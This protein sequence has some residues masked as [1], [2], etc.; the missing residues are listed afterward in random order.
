MKDSHQDPQA[1]SLRRSKNFPQRAG[2]PVCMQLRLWWP[3]EG[4]GSHGGSLGL[5]RELQA[6]PPPLCTRAPRPED[7][8]RSNRKGLSVAHH[9]TGKARLFGFPSVFTCHLTASWPPADTGNRLSD[10]PE[11]P[12]V[13]GADRPRRAPQLRRGRSRLVS[14]STQVLC[15]LGGGNST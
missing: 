10:S 7:R 15:P 14:P 11:R 4:G 9:S 2:S 12:R 3:V 6:A 5:R 13:S 8:Q 1:G